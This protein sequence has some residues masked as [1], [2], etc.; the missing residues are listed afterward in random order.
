MQLAQGGFNA[1]GQRLD[2]DTAA[3][4]GQANVRMAARGLGN[5]T[6]AEGVMRGVAQDAG[7]ARAQIQDNLT[8][9]QLGVGQ[10]NLNTRLRLLEAPQTQYPDAGLYARLLAQPGA[11][12][13]AGG[14]RMTRGGG[15]QGFQEAQPMVQQ[16]AQ[17][18]QMP[19]QGFNRGPA[20]GGQIDARMQQMQQ[21]KLQQFESGGR[22]ERQGNVTLLHRPEGVYYWDKGS[23]GWIRQLSTLPDL[24]DQEDQ[25]D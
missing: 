13:G 15:G 4:Q 7:L 21:N 23:Q 20:G 9:Q 8:R 16:G 22:I 17:Q 12:A 19:Q 3:A 6:A 25:R 5:S 24:P 11:A 2:R 1:A 10:N 14:G 18:Q